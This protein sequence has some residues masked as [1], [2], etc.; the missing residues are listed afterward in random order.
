MTFWILDFG[1]CLKI[2]MEMISRLRLPTVLIGIHETKRMT[3]MMMER[4]CQ[5][6]EE[7][8]ET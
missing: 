7:R 2:E 4:L 3:I 1:K 8:C 6:R 5:R